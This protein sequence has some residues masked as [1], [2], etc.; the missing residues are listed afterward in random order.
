MIPVFAELKHFDGVDF[1]ANLLPPGE[2][3]K[4]SFSSCVFSN[5][6]LS[7]IK[8]IDC[9]FSVCNLS[10]VK[11]SNTAFRDASFTEC[12][13]LAMHF[14]DCSPFGLSFT[15]A[16][17]ALQHSSFI[18]AKIPKTRF[19][20]CHLAETDFTECDLTGAVFDR[21]DLNRSKFSHTNI[22]KADFRTSVNYS[23]DPEQNRLKKARFSLPDVAGLLD[24]YD[25]EIGGWRDAETGMGS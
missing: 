7:G 8:F 18:K 15:F 19:I 25:I 2:Y 9:S 13:M 12:K 5:A 3:E 21:C 17:C 24:K 4:C 10:M 20:R 22:E 23:I 11:L 14:E 16:D 6:D 1:T